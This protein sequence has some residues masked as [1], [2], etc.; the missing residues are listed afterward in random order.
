M[1]EVKREMKELRRKWRIVDDFLVLF[2]LLCF[3]LTIS[4]LIITTHTKLN[5]EFLGS[6]LHKSENEWNI[7]ELCIR[8]LRKIRTTFFHP[9]VSSPTHKTSSSIPD[10]LW[11]DHF[12]FLFAFSFSPPSSACSVYWKFWWQCFPLAETII[13]I[14]IKKTLTDL[15][16]WQPQP[17][18]QH[19]KGRKNVNFLDSHNSPSLTT[20]FRTGNQTK[21]KVKAS[22]TLEMR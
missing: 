17:Q 8:W 16:C 6:L 12:F 9:L 18:R 13:K 7:F 15:D 2:L 21:P 22:Q 11:I 20:F 10:N 1:G 19:W 4:S 5:V 3:F 14:Y